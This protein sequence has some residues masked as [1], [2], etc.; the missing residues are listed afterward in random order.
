MH[1]SLDR[2]H[3][4]SFQCFDIVGFSDKKCIQPVKNLAPAVPKGS[5]L[6]DLWV[7]R[8]NLEWSSENRTIVIKVINLFAAVVKI[9]LVSVVTYKRE[10][11]WLP[12]GGEWVSEGLTSPST[13]RSF[14]RRVFP[15]SHLHGTDNLTRTTKRQNTQITQ[16]R[17]HNAKSGPS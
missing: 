1:Y 3:L 12:V 15:V 8:I 9:C 7:T 17:Y 4:T 14:R 13:H 11:W 5:S 6:G 16:H 2:Q 10:E